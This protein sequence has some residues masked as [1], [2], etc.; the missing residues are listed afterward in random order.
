M[1]LNEIRYKQAG[2][3]G[4]L[5]AFQLA[6]DTGL[7]DGISTPLFKQSYGQNS[8]PELL[9]EALTN[10]FRNSEGKSEAESK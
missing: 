8:S 1:K 3:K 4:D 5:K 2:G 7:E 10:L 9:L 6:F